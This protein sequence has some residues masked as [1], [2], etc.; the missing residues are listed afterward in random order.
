M[1]I[2]LLLFALLAPAYAGAG[3]RLGG[4][5]RPMLP[6][7]LPAVAVGAVE[8]SAAAAP[9][10]LAAEAGVPLHRNEQ[11]VASM[12]AL[13]D[14]GF[15]TLPAG[16]FMD[17][18][19][20]DRLRGQM[21]RLF[22]GGGFSTYPSAEFG[23]LHKVHLYDLEQGRGWFRDLGASRG[24]NGLRQ[25]VGDL[26]KALRRALPEERIK[27]Q[28]VEVRVTEPKNKA[29]F[30]EIHIDK[31]YFTVTYVLGDSPTTPVFELKRGGKVA[32]TRPVS[33]SAAILSGAYRE[34]AT[35]IPAT[36]HSAPFEAMKKRRHFVQII[37]TIDGETPTFTAAMRRR[38]NARISKASSVLGQAHAAFLEAGW[39][40]GE[41][42]RQFSIPPSRRRR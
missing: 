26:T 11:A 9:A 12:A 7:A 1:K 2:W 5:G 28:R 14:R 22:D 24:K 8:A 15:V 38:L 34:A 23:L 3:P 4:A 19:R 35:G 29:E 20:E 37:Y 36:L 10:A 40:S 30:D 18:R 41:P 17:A 16:A 21:D 32:I 39:E 27:L 42:E 33:R 25:L 31:K 13:R 6:P